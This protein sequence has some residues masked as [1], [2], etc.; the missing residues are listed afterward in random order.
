MLCSK[1]NWARLKDF[2]FQ[3]DLHIIDSLDLPTADPQYM[4]DF[5]RYRHWGDSV[6]I[7]DMYV[8]LLFHLICLYLN[9][10]CI[11]ILLEIFLMLISVLCSNDQMPENIVKATET[12]NTIGL[13]PAVGEF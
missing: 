9:W 12:L 10:T 1:G 8:A 2:A 7:V 5:V 3:D 6:L 11:S 4:M 13:I